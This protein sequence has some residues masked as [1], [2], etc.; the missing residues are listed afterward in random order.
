MS[1]PRTCLW[2]GTQFV[3]TRSDKLCCSRKCYYNHYDATHREA[4]RISAH[5][6]RNPNEPDVPMTQEVTCPGCGVKF[7]RNSA[8]HEYCTMEC[9]NKARRRDNAQWYRD[10]EPIYYQTYRARQLEKRPWRYMFQS[11]RLDAKN[12]GLEFSLTDEWAQARWTG[13]CEITNLRFRPGGVGR[14]GPNPFSPSIDRI[15]Q[16]IGYTKENC[17]FVLFAINGFRGAGTD[18]QMYTI[19]LALVT[20]MPRH[21]MQQVQS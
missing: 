1:E 2:C 3:P 6:R 9:R 14:A 12:R 13:A 11:R 7:L 21:L 19:A 18:E 10:H 15:D 8:P 4:R 17:R 5:N 20:N 16:S